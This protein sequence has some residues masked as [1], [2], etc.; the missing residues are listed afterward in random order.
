M[1]IPTSEINLVISGKKDKVTGLYFPLQT[2]GIGGYFTRGEGKELIRQS[3]I[4]IL[5]TTPGERPMLP[6][7]GTGLRRLAFSPRDSITTHQI[8]DEI[9]NGISKF[10]TRV[11]DVS[12]ST[13]N[14]DTNSLRIQLKYRIRDN[15]E[16]IESFQVIVNG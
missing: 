14:L 10:E 4:N 9:I 7:Y 11:T 3:I 8:S 15:Y 16:S 2:S 6:T 13:E 12:V 5:M 1:A